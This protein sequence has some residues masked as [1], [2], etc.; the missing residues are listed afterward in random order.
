MV[1]EIIPKKPIRYPF[2]LNILFYFSLVVLIISIIS[3][4]TLN[5]L[6]EKS[7]ETLKNLEETIA[8]ERTSERI[9]LEKTLFS[10]EK[11][12]DDFSQLVNKHFLVSDFFDFFQDICYPKVYFSNLAL[13]PKGSS[14]ALSGVVDSFSGLGQQILILEKEP[15]VKEVNLSNISIGKQGNIS[16]SLDLF[17]DSELFKP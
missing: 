17:L 5:Y 15:L 14:V 16:F 6:S 8:K 4:F 1:I 10:Y 9:G 12:I 11:K 13:N 2:W 7:S 3:F